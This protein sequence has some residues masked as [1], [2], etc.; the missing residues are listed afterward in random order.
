MFSLKKRKKSEDTEDANY[1]LSIGD[2]M[3]SILI[4]F[5]LKYSVILFVFSI[6]AGSFILKQYKL[7]NYQISS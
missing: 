3:A 7:I 5:I 2:L 4:I 1:W 6:F